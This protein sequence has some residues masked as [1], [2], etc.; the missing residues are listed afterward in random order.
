MKI[1]ANLCNGQYSARFSLRSNIPILPTFHYSIIPTLLLLFSLS[2]RA[3]THYV[4]KANGAPV[5]PFTNG[6]ASAAVNIQTAVNLAVDGDVVLVTNGSYNTD[7][8]VTPGYSL[9]NRIV[10]T[11]LIT[12]Q[13]MSANP[14]DTLIVGARDAGTGNNGPAAMRGVYLTKGTLIG[15]TVTNGFTRSS[16]NV[17]YDQSGGGILAI[18]NTIVISNCV[19]TDGGAYLRGGGIFLTNGATLWN[20]VV[21]TNICVSG[22]IGAGGGVYNNGYMY[23]CV[24]SNNTGQYGGG[25]Y[26]SPNFDCQIVNN[27][28][29][30]AGGG[31][32]GGVFIRCNILNNKT[33]IGGG[34]SGKGAGA[35][36]SEVINCVIAGNTAA[37][38]GGAGD[39]TT[40]FE[41]CTISNNFATSGSGAGNGTFANCLIVN[42]SCGDYP[43]VSQGGS[44]SNCT[45][46][47]NPPGPTPLGALYRCTNVVNC[48]VYSNAPNHSETYLTNSCTYPMPPGV[49]DMGGNIT[50]NPLFVDVIGGNYRLNKRSPCVNAGA[51]KEW[52]TNSMDLDGH[53]RIRDSRVDMGAYEYVPYGTFYL[54]R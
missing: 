21:R 23:N 13:A 4:N 19:V 6:W 31:G 43:A 44:F 30:F 11:N 26:G 5:S 50:N 2:V 8:M 24:I 32:Y 42:N 51:N 9:T 16:G 10:I 28:A 34:G 52:M 3:D 17:T 47:R 25:V 22:S 53:G 33:P 49:C 37:G 36:V 41:N 46:V 40:T 20:S 18:G 54:G 38:V 48:V 27:T 1:R 7:W 12:L 14:A 15:F 29:T 35:A 39:S 45:I